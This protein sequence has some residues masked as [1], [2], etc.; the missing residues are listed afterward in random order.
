MSAAT[1]Q[2]AVIEQHEMPFCVASALRP[3]TGA[4]HRAGSSL[5]GS[6]QMSSIA[7]SAWQ[8]TGGCHVEDTHH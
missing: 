2:T 4:R 8:S 1:M 7:R 3:V 5:N 6:A